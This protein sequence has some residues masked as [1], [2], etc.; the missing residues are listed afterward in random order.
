M[1]A[2]GGTA[3]IGGSNDA[4]IYSATQFQISLAC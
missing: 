2:I 1:S 3:D 4:C